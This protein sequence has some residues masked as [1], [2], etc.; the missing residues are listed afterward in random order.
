MS[1]VFSLSRKNVRFLYFLAISDLT[2]KKYDIES[3]LEKEGEN[4]KKLLLLHL[5][6]III[7]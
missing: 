2:G 4:H 7:T 5:N 6:M 1:G 3:E